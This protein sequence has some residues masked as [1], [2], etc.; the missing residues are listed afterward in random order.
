MLELTI[1]SPRRVIYKGGA[2]SVIVPGEQG[3][4]ELLEFHKNILSRLA[5]GCIVVDNKNLYNIKRGVIKL[6][7]NEVTVIVEEA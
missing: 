4:F 5:R 1:I 6:E 7:R 2:K 3:V